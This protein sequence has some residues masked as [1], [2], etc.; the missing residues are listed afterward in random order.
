MVRRP[1]LYT[2]RISLLLLVLSGCAHEASTTAPPTLRL[3]IARHGQTDWNAER[4]LQG[5]TDTQLNDTGRRQAA[6]LAESLQ[7][8]RF[9]AVYSSTL[10]RSRE[11]AE[12]LRRDVPLTSLAGLCEQALGKFEGLHLAGADSAAVAEFRRRSDDPEDT[13]DGGE[14]ANQFFARVRAAVDTIRVRHASGSILVVGHG[15]TNQMILRA[16]LDLDAAQAD[17]IHQANDELYLLEFAAG[18]P[19]RLW[20]RITT[21]NLGDL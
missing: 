7:G 18:L 13:L 19:P 15:G 16:L 9:D 14:S 12:I 20:K 3:Y 10:R 5:Q 11:T 8:V 2:L 6:Q 1:V 17:S 4:R 21:A